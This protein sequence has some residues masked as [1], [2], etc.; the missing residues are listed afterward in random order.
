MPTV[1]LYHEA[2]AA[3]EA[4]VAPLTADRLAQSCTACPAWSIQDVVAH[5]V[6]VV[7]T[8]LD[9]GL[10]ATTFTAIVAS[11]EHERAV[12]ASVRDRWTDE[13][14]LARRGRPLEEVFAEWDA[15]ITG[16]DDTTAG[17]A[18]DLVVHLDDIAETLGRGDPD[19][20]PL[21]DAVL[22]GWYHAFVRRRLKGVGEGPTMG[23]L[24]T[25]TG[26]R[27]GTDGASTVGGTTYDLLRTI[28]SRRTRAEADHRIDWGDTPELVR[29]MLPVYG[30][31]G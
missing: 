4:L 24:A 21:R 1:A 6:H 22:T 14:V 8:Y 23:L 18:L 29:S 10:P 26:R 12:A 9:G 19:P 27:W 31:P 15:V 13:G 3:T 11:D 17:V 25:D 20:S 16:I 7:T 2:K 28:V 5:H 30:W